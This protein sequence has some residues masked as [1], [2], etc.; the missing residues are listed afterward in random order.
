MIAGGAAASITLLLAF[1]GIHK[2]SSDFSSAADSVDKPSSTSPISEIVPASKV[3]GNKHISS[4]PTSSTVGKSSPSS[5][6]GAPSGL[7]RPAEKNED[8]SDQQLK[9]TQL[10]GKVREL[11]AAKTE[12]Q[13]TNAKLEQETSEAKTALEAKN[14]K[15]Q[16]AQLGSEALDEKE[17]ENQHVNTADVQ[18]LRDE[19][20]ALDQEVIPHAGTMDEVQPIQH[21]IEELQKKNQELEKEKRTALLE[22]ET[23]R[24]T[25]KTQ[26][27]TVEGL[28]PEIQKCFQPVQKDVRKNEWAQAVSLIKCLN[29]LVV[30]LIQ[31]RDDDEPLP[32]SS[33]Q[34]ESDKNLAEMLASANTSLENKDID[35]KK[36][37]KN[38]NQPRRKDNA[39]DVYKNIINNLVPSLNSVGIDTAE[40]SNHLNLLHAGANRNAR[41]YII[42]ELGSVCT[43][44]IKKLKPDTR[45][46]GKKNQKRKLSK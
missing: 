7:V 35:T 1:G 15:L 9:I 23:L 40:L 34:D 14:K 11:E 31:K 24:E 36:P 46:S 33:M 43:E 45:S 29:D 28:F 27:K 18:P 21:Q 5:S 26:L 13:T 25:I 41:V 12:L 16:E 44:L 8:I 6:S 3:G 30:V 22:I 38:V 4:V 19:I 37:Q 17:P 32:K 39:A 42:K 20:E 10:E 2:L